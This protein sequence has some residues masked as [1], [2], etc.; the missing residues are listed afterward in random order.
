MKYKTTLKLIIKN[1]QIFCAICKKWVD[2]KNWMIHQQ[3]C[4]Q[5]MKDIEDV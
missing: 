3:C 5:K 4:L 1:N 2:T